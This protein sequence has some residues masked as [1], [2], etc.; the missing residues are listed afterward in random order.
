MSFFFISYF[1]FL[2]TQLTRKTS[3]SLLWQPQRQQLWWIWHTNTACQHTFVW[4]LMYCE[5]FFVFE[6][7]T[8]AHGVGFLKNFDFLIANVYLGLNSLQLWH[9]TT[10]PSTTP[11]CDQHQPCQERAPHPSPQRRWRLETERVVEDGS[12]KGENDDKALRRIRIS[13]AWYIFLFYFTISMHIY[14]YCRSVHPATPPSS[15]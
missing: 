1:L 10:L 4:A 6:H 2:E 12:T 11:Q 14:I 8:R 5:F 13:S 15:T 9:L 7:P 3:T